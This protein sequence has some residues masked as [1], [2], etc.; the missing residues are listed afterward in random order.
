MNGQTV[1]AAG[2]NYDIPAK[3]KALQYSGPETFAVVEIDVPDIGDDDV[4][5]KISACGVCGTV[6]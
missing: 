2:K 5:V 6:C 4:L 1:A 3:M